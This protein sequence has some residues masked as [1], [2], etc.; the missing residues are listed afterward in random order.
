MRTSPHAFR[1]I[2]LAALAILFPTGSS[3][4]RIIDAVQR[5]DLSAL[6]QMLQANPGSAGAGGTDG[7]TPLHW[8]AKLGRLQMIELLL[9]Y[10]AD[11]NARQPG[12]WTPLHSS[13]A[14]NQVGAMKLLYDHGADVR[15]TTEAGNAPIHEAAQFDATNVIDFLQSVGVDIDTPNGEGNSPLAVAAAY[16]RMA[17]GQFLV[18][19]G[20]SLSHQNRAVKTALQEAV[21]SGKTDFAKMLTEYQL[22]LDERA[23]RDIA[24]KTSGLNLRPEYGAWADPKAVTKTVYTTDFSTEAPGPEWTNTPL[25]PNIGQLRISTTPIGGRRFLGDFGNQAILLTLSDLPEHT[26]ISLSFDLF[27]IRSMDGNMMDGGPD[28]WTLAIT[29][30]PTLLQTTFQNHCPETN[31]RSASLKLQA[32]PGEYPGDHNTPYSGASERNSLGYKFRWREQEFPLDAVYK[33]RYTFAHDG[34]GTQIRFAAKNLEPLDNESW[35]IANVRVAV[36]VTPAPSAAPPTPHAAAIR[37]TSKTRA[38]VTTPRRPTVARR[39][40]TQ[41]AKKAAVRKAKPT[42]APSKSPVK[43]L[44][45][46]KQAPAP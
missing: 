41:R 8:A 4:Q 21:R 14:A 39:H 13:A 36:G 6:R 12:G 37:T 31:T 25:G 33:L 44:H 3:A 9:S 32:Y 24:R 17:T 19:A 18:A 38:P 11:V 26:E 5:N 1:I 30:G 28:I 23:E 46:K 2:L 27:M 20:A 42:R 16:G 10:R 29:D 15:A 45:D 7:A 43:R 22:A 40:A 35:G 34:R